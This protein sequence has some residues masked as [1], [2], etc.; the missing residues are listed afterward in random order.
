MG[1][2]KKIANSI[3]GP[4][5]YADLSG[6]P[7]SYSM[8]YFAVL[9]IMFSLVFAIIF[10]GSSII[11]VKNF[12]NS[13]APSIVS[14]F[15][16][17]LELVLKNG[18][19][20]SNVEEPYYIKTP[21]SWKVE[22]KDDGVTPENLIVIATKQQADLN[23]FANH[24]TMFL[25][26][27]DY[28]IFRESDGKIKATPFQKFPDTTINRQMVS[29]FVDKYSPYLNIIYPFIFIFIFFGAIMFSTL[30]LL[31]LLFAALIVW[32]I[33]KIRGIQGGYSKAYQYSLHLITAPLIYSIFFPKSFTF[34]FTL[35]FLIVGIVNIRKGSSEKEQEV[36]VEEEAK[37]SEEKPEV[38]LGEV[39][40]PPANPVHSK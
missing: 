38:P 4:K 39:L 29:F 1:I 16:E 19:L 36:K 40:V 15:P 32:I 5:F 17:E 14:N 20:S 37:P 25:L 34:S 21:D 24:D 23:N 30:R 11:K 10:G 31:Y 3:Y 35:I 6:K 2:F 9:S 13:I 22:N 7:F 27:A 28:V 18:K 33:F 8:G 26:T 12:I